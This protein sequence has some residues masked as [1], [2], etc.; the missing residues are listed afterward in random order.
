MRVL[1][2]V[3]LAPTLLL[4]GILVSGD[5]LLPHLPVMLEPLAS[6][7]PEAAAEARE[8][9]SFGPSDRVFPVLSDQIVARREVTWG[10]LP[11]WEPDL[12]LG[13]PLFANSIAGLGYPPNWRALV[14][15]PDR[16]AAPLA[17]LTLMI[18][19]LGMALFLRRLGFGPFA[20]AAGVIGVQV[21]GWGVSNLVYFM[22]VD[23]VVWFPW[24][25]WA[26]EGMARGVRRSG[27][28]LALFTALS[29]LAGFPP[30]ATFSIAA[31]LAYAYAGD[32]QAASLASQRA[33]ALGYPR[34]LLTSDP[35]LA[36]AWRERR[37][38]ANRFT[39]LFLATPDA[40][41]PIF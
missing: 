31:A 16:A 26:V 2:L 33:L 18:A 24:C 15:A 12:G 30:I 25:L 9:V 41:L 29:L 28:W 34:V 38:V 32:L 36:A 1:A 20:V 11:T 6:E 4:G 14:L 13:V 7:H 35:L 37:F 5:R 10:A 27:L 23:A 3:V 40:K 22:K 21:G 19:G 39:A 8:G 17:W